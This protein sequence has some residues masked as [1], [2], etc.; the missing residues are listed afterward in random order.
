MIYFG[1]L[2]GLKH[3]EFDLNGHPFPSTLNVFTRVSAT[4]E[5]LL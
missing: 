5:I 1:I 4:L 3:V 2:E